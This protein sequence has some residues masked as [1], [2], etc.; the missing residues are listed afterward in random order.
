MLFRS[1]PVVEVN[2][3]DPL[4]RKGFRAKGP[5]RFL[6]RDDAEFQSLLPQFAS[7][8][9]SLAE[10][11]RGIVVIKVDEA[12]PL[13]SPAYDNG[14]QEADLRQQWLAN[15]QALNEAYFSK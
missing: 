11:I 12:R 7:G 5:A 15:F 6:P 3:V 8:W 13:T 9:G 2:F 1:N 10:R 4:A 14:A